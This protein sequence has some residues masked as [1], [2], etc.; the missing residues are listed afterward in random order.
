MITIQPRAAHAKTNNSGANSFDH[1]FDSFAAMKNDDLR[2]CF[3]GDS[4]VAGTN[5]PEC[6]G[7]TGRISALARR[8]G[9]NLTPYNLGIRRDTSRDIAKRWLTEVVCRLPD[10]CRPYV[11]FSFGVNDT[12]IENGRRRVE[13]KQSI[14]CMRSIL[15]SAGKRY[16]VLMIGPPPIA[17][18]EQNERTKDLAE[19]MARV[20]AE[21]GV[22]FLP[23]FERLYGDAV[24]MSEV[25]STDG[26]HPGVDGYAKLATLID[27]WDYWWFKA[28]SK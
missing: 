24:W 26:A 5:D 22:P 20:A 4:F 11:V 23:V 10:P 8:R 12:T 16:D 14:E 28:D 3:V 7:W 17:D 2:I 27:Q 19:L 25:N 6:L 15:A 18:A 13:V 1:R 21:E 9:Y